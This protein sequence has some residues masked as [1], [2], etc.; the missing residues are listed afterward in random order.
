MF[1]HTYAL[2]WLF[3]LSTIVSK[4]MLPQSMSSSYSA[5]FLKNADIQESHRQCWSLR[6]QAA[7]YFL[8]ALHWKK[9]QYSLRGTLCSALPLHPGPSSWHTKLRILL[10]YLRNCMIKLTHKK[11]KNPPTYMVKKKISPKRSGHFC[12]N[13][14]NRCFIIAS[15][16]YTINR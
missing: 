1:S 4:N 16:N 9:S 5:M 3:R 2:W 14:E 7:V 12:C 8:L 11:T 15:D 13:N 6:Q 10:M